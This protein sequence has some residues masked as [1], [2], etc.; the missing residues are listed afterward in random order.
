MSRY[1]VT[2]PDVPIYEFDPGTMLDGQG[3][4]QEPNV[5]YI[6]ARMDVTT[7]AKVQNAMTSASQT[8]GKLEVEIRPGDNILALLVHNI[9]RWAGPDLGPIPCTPEMIGKLDTSDPHVARVLAEIGDRNK[10][11]PSPNPKAAAGNTLLSVGLPR[12]SPSP[13]A[14]EGLPVSVNGIEK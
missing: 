4:G 2:D 11:T 8:D 1:F 10:P 12:S 9:T 3:Q 5:I 6:R 13:A 14:A 7:R